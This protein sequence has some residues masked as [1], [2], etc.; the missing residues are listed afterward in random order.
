MVLTVDDSC[1]TVDANDDAVDTAVDRPLVAAFAMVDIVDTV[2]A[3]D[4][5]VDAADAIDAVLPAMRPARV[6]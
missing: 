3:R 6:L 1:D 5:A 4:D 2:D